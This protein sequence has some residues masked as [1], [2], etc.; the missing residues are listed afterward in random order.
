MDADGDGSRLKVERQLLVDG[1]HQHN[2]KLRVF[3][4]VE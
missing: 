2:E 4:V 3:P 1:D